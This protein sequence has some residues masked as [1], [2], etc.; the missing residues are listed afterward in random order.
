[1]SMPGMLFALLQCQD[2]R[3]GTLIILPIQHAL[4]TGEGTCLGRGSYVEAVHHCKNPRHEGCWNRLYYLRGNALLEL[5]SRTTPAAS[6]LHL[7]TTY[8]ITESPRSRHHKT[9]RSSTWDLALWQGHHEDDIVFRIAPRCLK[10]LSSLGFSVS[11]HMPRVVRYSEQEL[12][13]KIVLAYP[14]GDVASGHGCTQTIEITLVIKKEASQ[15]WRTVDFYVV[16]FLGVPINNAESPSRFHSNTTSPEVADHSIVMM[17]ASMWGNEDYCF[18]HNRRTLLGPTMTTT[19]WLPGD[20]PFRCVVSSDPPKCG[21]GPQF[22]SRSLEI[23]VRPFLDDSDTLHPNYMWLYIDLSEKR[24]F[25][26]QKDRLF[27]YHG[28]PY[29]FND[30]QEDQ[31][32]SQSGDSHEDTEVHLSSAGFATSST[33]VPRESLPDAPFMWDRK[34]PYKT[35]PSPTEVGRISLPGHRSSY[36]A[37]SRFDKEAEGYFPATDQDTELSSALPTASPEPLV[38]VLSKSTD[39]AN[40]DTVVSEMDSGEVGADGTPRARRATDEELRL[41]A[42]AN[43]QTSLVARAPEP[44]A[45]HLNSSSNANSKDGHP[46]SKSLAPSS[47]AHPQDVQELASE[48][49]GALNAGRE[50]EDHDAWRRENDALRTRISAMSTQLE[51]LASRNTVMEAENARLSTQMATVLA[52]LEDLPAE[53]GPNAAG[54]VRPSNGPSKTSDAEVQEPKATPIPAVAPSKEK[55]KSCAVTFSPASPDPKA[56]ASGE[57]ALTIHAS[58]ESSRSLDKEDTDEANTPAL[59]GDVA[60][61]PVETVLEERDQA[62]EHRQASSLPLRLSESGVGVESIPE[63]LPGHV[64]ETHSAASIADERVGIL[65][66]DAEA[67]ENSAERKINDIGRRLVNVGKD[68][69]EPVVCTS[70][71]MV[72]ECAPELLRDRFGELRGPATTPSQDTQDVRGMITPRVPIATSTAPQT[73]K[74]RASLGDAP[75]VSPILEDQDFPSGTTLPSSAH[76]SPNER[77][78]TQG[79]LTDTRA[80]KRPRPTMATGREPVAGRGT[81]PAHAPAGLSAIVRFGSACWS[82]DAA[83]IRLEVRAIAR[84]A[85]DALP[86]L[87]EAVVDVS[88]DPSSDTYVLIEFPSTLLAQVFVDVWVEKKN[89][90]PNHHQHVQAF[91]LATVSVRNAALSSQIDAILARPDALTTPQC[92]I[93]PGSDA[94]TEGE[95]IA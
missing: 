47:S 74:T 10:V 79:D 30:S 41:R 15:N 8:E 19:Q 16:N 52:R 13:V 32:V 95:G 51:C 86:T 26:L 73:T 35:R 64:A 59:R 66:E 72:T 39:G 20:V 85:W 44:Y 37:P 34:S 36:A 65:P 92:G 57:T 55:G 62:F 87:F 4:P 28:Q 1:M 17:A 89:L 60:V 49:P 22:T 5:L 78:R 83:F 76:T 33:F 94:D 84:A 29:S 14:S 46:S 50:P 45:S 71:S 6:E 18:Y 67:P 3:D 25:W 80:P 77:T 91:V 31:E 70:T 53:Q 63:S 27:W 61:E 56:T 21:Q 75:S 81:A 93:G 24:T 43:R 23:S 48:D 2:R 40:M 58:L 82:A 38:R 88:R 9:Y 54:D 90:T 42:A 69:R 7:L 68:I 12:S 11:S